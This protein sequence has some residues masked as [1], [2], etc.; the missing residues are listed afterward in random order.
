MNVKFERVELLGIL[1]MLEEKYYIEMGA[2][3]P[4]LQLIMFVV[5]A[6]NQL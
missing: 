1:K 4:L 3:F 2:I 5:Q 6:C